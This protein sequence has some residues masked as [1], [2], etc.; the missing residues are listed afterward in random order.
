MKTA[1]ALI[2]LTTLALVLGL[3]PGAAGATS[4]VDCGPDDGRDR[5]TGQGFTSEFDAPA[6][7]APELAASH[8]VTGDLV[9]PWRSAP[10]AFTADFAPYKTASV[11]V[12]L[13]WTNPADYDLF[14]YADDGSE[15]ARSDTS[16]IDAQ[17]IGEEVV[18]DL[19]HC[20]RF[21]IVAKSWAGRPDEKL[22]LTTTVTPS[23]QLLAC[24]AGDT[25]P[26][27]AGKEAGQAP[28]PVADTRTRLYLGGDPGQ[29]SMLHA[30]QNSGVPF[31]GT[32]APG[33]PTSG[34]PNQHTRALVGFHDQWQNPLVP[35]FTINFS[36]PRAIKGDVTAVLY[37]SSAT[38]DATSFLYTTLFANGE[39]VKSVEIK[40]D[41]VK[42]D[43]SPIAVTFAGVDVAAAESLTLQIAAK[44]V[45]TSGGQT[46]NP[47]DALLTLEYGSVQFPSRVTLP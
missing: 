35:H 41:S 34:T 6:G 12:T 40:G 17:V 21:T 47:R 28:D 9:T 7:T 23:N 20:D 45:A 38:F 16:N 1:R 10:F 43:P 2:P 24:V 14:V 11:K 44:P 3:V 25:A 36:E 33:R 29:I 5:L 46:G 15:L 13:G 4:A 30:Y 42:R 18:M 37:A 8:D 32:L 27:C 39:A 19:T 31:R 26:G 22:R